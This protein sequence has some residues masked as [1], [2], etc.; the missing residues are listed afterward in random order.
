[1]YAALILEYVKHMQDN[2]DHY[3]PALVTDE[4]GATYVWDSSD[5]NEEEVA[6][7]MQLRLPLRDKIDTAFSGHIN[8]NGIYTG[9]T[10]FTFLDANSDEVR[11]TVGPGESDGFGWLTGRIGLTY[12]LNGKLMYDQIIFG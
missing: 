2:I 5:A 10:N 6:L 4:H 11:V 9:A 12:Q 7:I 3:E 8:A 1:M